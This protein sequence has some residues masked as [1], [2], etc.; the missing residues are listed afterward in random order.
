MSPK[1]PPKIGRYRLNARQDSPDFRDFEYRP[2]LRT[3]APTWPIPSGLTVRDQGTTGACTGFGLAA[4]IDCLIGRSVE[5]ATTGA[6]AVSARM[7]HEMGKRFDEWPGEDYEGSSCRGAI[8][9]WYNMGVCREALYPLAGARRSAWTIEAAK[10]ARR[11][12]VGAYYRLGRRVSDYH[13]A[14]N[15]TGAVYCSAQIHAGWRRRDAADGLIPYADHRKLGGHAF[16][17]VG[18]DARGFWI[19]N[20]WGSG[21]G[22][23][24]FALWTYEDWQ[25]HVLD[26]W[27]VQMALPTP[28]IW[29]LPPRSPSPRSDAEAAPSPTRAEIAGHFAHLDDGRFHDEGRYWSTLEDVRLTAGHVSGSDRYRHLLFYAHGGLNTPRD[30]ARRIAAMKQVFKANGIY[31]YHL[32]YDTGILEELKDVIVGRRQ[33]ADQRAGGLTDWIDRLIEQLARV[34][35]RALWREMKS[36][37]ERPFREE[38]A[39]TQLLGAFHDAFEAGGRVPHIHL[40]G[41]STGMILLAHLLQRL[42]VTA[43][44]W[45]I[46]T[47]SLMAPAGTVDLFTSLIQPLLKATSPA[48]RISEMAVYNLDDAAERSDRVAWAYNK[49]L[50]YLVSRAFEEQRP[51]RI[52]GM[53]RYCRAVERRSLPRL[54]I[55]YSKGNR[56]AARITASKDHGG[57]D[58]DPATMNH[59]L[60]RILRAGR[61]KPHGEFSSET[62]RY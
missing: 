40:A 53:Q 4:V 42:S 52:L 49:S 28:Q 19:Q 25:R 46:S 56:G 9:G 33:M 44:R 62:L 17:I 54:R 31:P 15:E 3:L 41:H 59:I 22:R 29:H 1:Q 10:D 26:A 32:M 8:K 48:F 18:Y 38:H 5:A 37:A 14:V 51:A 39:G 7:L 13:A 57:F 20:S 16:A 35:G 60:R 27:V 58:N 30:S 12:T 45:H 47:V 6:E 11:R 34:P 36:G 55:H 23:D 2:T 61:Q 50:L 21:W 43:P 24:G